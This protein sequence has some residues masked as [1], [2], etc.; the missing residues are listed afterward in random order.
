M[1]EGLEDEKAFDAY[2]YPEFKKANSKKYLTPEAKSLLETKKPLK[3]DSVVM[4]KGNL[5][6]IYSREEKQ[7][8]KPR[9]ITEIEQ[10]QAYESAK[11]YLFE[12]ID[13]I[14]EYEEIKK[15]MD[16]YPKAIKHVDNKTTIYKYNLIDEDTG[17]KLTALY[18][19]QEETMI[20]ISYNDPLNTI[21]KNNMSKDFDDLKTGHEDHLLEEIVS[22]SKDE[23]Q[24][25]KK[26]VFENKKSFFSYLKTDID[27]KAFYEL[28]LYTIET[29]YNNSNITNQKL[30]GKFMKNPEIKKE[31]FDLDNLQ[32]NMD[33]KVMKLF[34]ALEFSPQIGSIKRDFELNEYLASFFDKVFR[35]L[36]TTKENKRLDEIR[37][38]V[39]SSNISEEDK[40]SLQLDRHNIL[41]IKSNKLMFKK[42]L[43]KWYVMR[44]FFKG[45]QSSYDIIYN[46]TR[47]YIEEGEEGIEQK[48]EF[49]M[50]Y[51]KIEQYMS[52]LTQT[53][54]R[55]K[56]I[57]RGLGSSGEFLTSKTF[58]SI[59][60][61][62]YDL[63]DQKDM[64]ED[65]KN[66]NVG[67]IIN[68]T[69]FEEKISS[70][71]S[72]I[73]SLED[74]LKNKRSR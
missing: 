62:A 42:L 63:K 15:V 26:Q 68:S 58:E 22:D 7:E 17:F 52:N 53:H 12:Q 30:F 28:F 35:D 14:E 44:E 47:A 25:L 13:A 16:A 57:K 70:L 59:N 55:L 67:K 32:E 48:H 9:K 10:K 21:K 54:A 72:K 27:R 38:D 69:Y 50:K 34:N 24:E 74:K 19:T 41:N 65:I 5:I 3:R 4:A 64:L 33:D 39:K 71:N 8:Y 61:I 20:D 11:K 29:Y 46:K 49:L 36:N 2:H 73:L 45:L 6:T 56:S 1:V 37:F 66:L 31:I 43:E 40:L 51:E 18:D 60:F 23:K